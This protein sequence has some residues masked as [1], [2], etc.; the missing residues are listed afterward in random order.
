MNY[1]E[2]LIDSDEDK[3]V[4]GKI[5]RQIERMKSSSCIMKKTTCLSNKGDPLTPDIRALIQSK[6]EE[7]KP[8]RNLIFNPNCKKEIL[9]NHLRKLHS[10]LVYGLYNLNK[11][12]I[13]EL[14][15]KDVHLGDSKGFFFLSF[16]KKI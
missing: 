6:S 14:I 5:F 1:P 7:Y 16:F 11:N 12:N 15:T 13:D 10:S 2:N 3:K 8:F 9:K 4:A